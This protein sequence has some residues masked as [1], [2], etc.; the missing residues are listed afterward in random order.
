[1][2]QTPGRIQKVDPPSGSI[3][4][5]IG[6]FESIIGAS[7]TYYAILYHTVYTIL[8]SARLVHF[9]GIYFLDPPGGNEGL[10]TLTLLRLARS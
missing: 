10:K 7:I 6:V 1:M 5:T 2:S 8:Y 4:Y 9:W 3:I